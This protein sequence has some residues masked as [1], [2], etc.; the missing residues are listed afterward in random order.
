MSKMLNARRRHKSA[1][2]PWVIAFLI[3]LVLGTG[4]CSTAKPPTETLSRA[5]L[6]LRAASEARAA[7]LAPMD[8][9]SAREKLEGSKQAIAA[10]RYEDA[11]RLAESAQVEAELA[12]AK[13]EAEIMRQAAEELR[14]RIDVLRMETELGSKKS[15]VAASDKE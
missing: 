2:P 14:K 11:R 9:Q 7:E 4:A 12:E 13:A 10:Q 15:S 5:E 1:F 8:L 6:G 3:I